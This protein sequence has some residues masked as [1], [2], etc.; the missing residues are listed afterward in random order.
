MKLRLLIFILWLCCLLS[1]GASAAARFEDCGDGTV[2][3]T[4]TKQLW[5]KRS[6]CHY[7][8][9]YNASTWASGLANGSCNLSDGSKA[10]DWHLPS[11]DELKSLI[12]GNGAPLWLCNG[13]DGSNACNPSGAYPYIWLQAQGMPSEAVQAY[14]YW[15]S[16]TYPG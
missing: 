15:S 2:A 10:G 5:L 7:D 13:C 11:V 14:H 3:D 12:C 9:W 1:S 4:I 8:T 16:S 6:T